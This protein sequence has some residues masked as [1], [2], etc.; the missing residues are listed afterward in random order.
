MVNYADKALFEQTSV[1]KQFHIYTDNESVSLT[2]AQLFLEEFELDESLCSSEELRFGS[3]EACG[4]QFT[5]VNTGF[6]SLKGEWI[7]VDI[8]PHGAEETF[9]VGRYKVF[10]DK[11]TSHK[12]RREIVAYD[13]LYYVLDS[14][15]EDWYASLWDTQTTS[16][17]VKDFRDAF[18]EEVG[19]TQETASLINDD[20]V[21]Q[22]TLDSG[23]TLSGKTILNSICEFNG[24]FGHIGRDGIFHYISLENKTPTLI[25]NSQ[26][27]ESDYE[28][29]VTKTIDNLAIYSA[30]GTFITA[31]GEALYQN[32]YQIS[33]NI[34]I[35]NQ[36]ATSIFVAA[37]RL[38]GKIR[39]ITYRAFEGDFKGN[40][41]YE[42]G[43]AIS[44]YD[45]E[46]VIPT[47]L[48]QRT[49]R[50]IQSLRDNYRASATETYEDNANSASKISS[51][52][53]KQINEVKEMDKSSM[54]T[55]I[56]HNAQSIVVEESTQTLLLSFEFVTIDLAALVLDVMA[57]LAIETTE[58]DTDEEYDAFNDAV[59]T[60]RFF[61]DGI[62]LGYTFTETWQDGKHILNLNFAFPSISISRHTFA[63][64]I[65]IDGGSARLEI[66][67]LICIISGNGLLPTDAWDGVITASDSFYTLGFSD[68]IAEFEDSGECDNVPTPARIVSDGVNLL[69]FSGY[70]PTNYLDTVEM[71]DELMIFTTSVNA[72]YLDYTATITNS[73]FMNGEVILPKLSGITANRIHGSNCTFYA[74][75]DDGV[76]WLAYSESDGW[77]AGASMTIAEFV[78]LPST[79]WTSMGDAI[80]K[81]IVEDEAYLQ[82]IDVINGVPVPDE[83]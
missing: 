45:R 56:Y 12:S 14:S 47:Y 13:P 38:L 74:S 10:S 48:L 8:M 25:N 34:L 55:Y 18:F 76:T 37:Q 19:I 5:A 23:N 66:N 6:Q 69:T 42:V 32:R 72:E 36:D 1:D 68:Y 4:V 64:Y 58:D 22:N 3:C 50:G 83:D 35:Y 65:T 53:I 28:D 49:M 39:T 26:Q 81:V 24:V 79:A 52:L 40:P 70:V 9:V 51:N 82:E 33:G 71:E 57:N 59:G 29:F 17:T 80:I 60:V 63:I 2:N 46:T 41:C 67:D 43:D 7:N 75:F 54:Q 30:T 73:R 31:V 20:F 61:L 11:P 77:V 16:M 27:I 78:S 15:M 21:I 62:D 44:F